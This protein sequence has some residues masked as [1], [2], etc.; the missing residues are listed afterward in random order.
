VKE[1]FNVLCDLT[2]LNTF[3]LSARKHFRAVMDLCN[4]NG[5]SRI[6]RIIPDPLN[7]FG[8]TVMSYFHYA[9]G[10]KII[11]CSDLKEALEHLK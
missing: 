1:G 9:K 10:V 8:L 2:A 4:K 6:I 7:N 3:D 5:V 11:T